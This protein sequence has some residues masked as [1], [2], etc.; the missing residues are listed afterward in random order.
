M[1]IWQMKRN[2]SLT[3]RQLLKFYIALVCLSLLVATGFLLAGAWV[4][5]IFTAVEL[6]VVTV[7]FLIYCRH[8]VDYEEIQI[9]GH[10]LIVRKMIGSKESDYVFNTRLLRVEPPEKG[11]K[12]FFIAQSDNRVEVGQFVQKEQLMILVSQLRA[13]L[14]Q[15]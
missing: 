15:R 9:D 8:A 13:N 3:P 5:P 6:T 11:K 4:V 14:G 1:K 12:V 10:T 7:G 2:C